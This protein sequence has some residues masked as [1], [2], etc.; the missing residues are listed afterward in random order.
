MSLKISSIFNS[1][2]KR[3]KEKCEMDLFV[4]NFDER[5]RRRRRKKS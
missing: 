3:I 4:F 1:N 2:E 5:K